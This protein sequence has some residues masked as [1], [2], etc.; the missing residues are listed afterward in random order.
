[1]DAELINAFIDATRYVLETMASTKYAGDLYRKRH[2]AHCLQH[3]WRG[4]E[5][6]E[7]GD[8]RRCM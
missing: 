6:I 2:P 7:R 3:G 1:V 8:T 5:G 4:N